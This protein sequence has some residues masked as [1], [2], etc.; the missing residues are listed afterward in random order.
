MYFTLTA[1]LTLTGTFHVLSSH[2]WLVVAILDGA[3]LE[4][5]PLSLGVQRWEET[6]VGRQELPSLSHPG[7]CLK[8]S[9]R[10]D[11][12]LSSFHSLH[13]LS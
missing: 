9:L 5:P 4:F 7:S 10:T 2:G 12:S 13:S 11:G 8:R 1:H 6:G 3:A